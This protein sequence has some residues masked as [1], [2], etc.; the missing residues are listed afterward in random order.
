[1]LDTRFPRIPGDVGNEHSFS[2]PILKKVVPG[3]STR[4][5]VTEGDSSLLE[6]FLAAARE[7]EEE[8]ADAITTSCGFLAMFQK[9]LSEA[10]HVP[11]FTSSLLQCALLAPMLRGDEVIGILTSDGRTLGERHFRGV[12]I[13]DVPKVVYGLEG[14]SV[15]DVFVGGNPDLDPQR[16]QQEMISVACRMVAEHPEVGPIVF[17]C[18]NMPPYAAAVSRATGRA[19]YDITTLA[20]TVMRSLMRTEFGR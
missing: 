1:M 4:R 11:V 18:T 2:F 5:V 17:E 13:S 16:A 10:V 12:G 7:L 15:N 20:E 6:P 14:T 9:E 8:G 19:V 3:A